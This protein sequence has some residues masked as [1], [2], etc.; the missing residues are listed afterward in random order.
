MIQGGKDIAEVQPSQ[1]LEDG[2]VIVKQGEVHTCTIDNSLL[3]D[4]GVANWITVNKI[5]LVPVTAGDPSEF[6]AKLQAE[7]TFMSVLPLSMSRLSREIYAGNNYLLDE[8]TAGQGQDLYL[9]ATDVSRKT[10]VS[11]QGP[12][13]YFIEEILQQKCPSDMFAF[14]P[15]HEDGGV[16]PGVENVPI[17]AFVSILANGGGAPFIAAKV[18]TP[19]N[20][21][22]LSP[23][24]WSDSP[25]E[26]RCV[27]REAYSG[28]KQFLIDHGYLKDG[29]DFRA[30]LHQLAL[31]VRKET[32]YATFTTQVPQGYRGPGRTTEV[33]LSD[34]RFTTSVGQNMTYDFTEIPIGAPISAAG[35][36]EMIRQGPLSRALIDFTAKT[37]GL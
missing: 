22:Q 28:V 17:Q 27:V 14:H 18:V 10:I 26:K 35:G 2:L 9:V 25:N 8:A 30:A 24:V 19:K 29:I 13:S 31:D 15:P 37:C 36:A 6:L 23:G 4:Q 33:Y 7:Q 20:P 21:A 16:E 32:S 11:R 3:K 34:N 1:D 5:N 12:F